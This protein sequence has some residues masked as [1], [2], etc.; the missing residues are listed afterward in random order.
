MPVNTYTFRRIEKKYL[1]NRETFNA[2]FFGIR[3][4]IVGDEYGKSTIC[5]AYL[6]TPDYRL[7]RTSLDAEDYKEK[8]RLRSYGKAA[9]NGTVFLEIKKKCG[10]V[11]YKRRISTQYASAI[12]YIINGVA[13]PDSQIQ[14]EIDY[15]MSFYGRPRPMSVI[16]YEREAFFVSELPAL[17]I[18]FDTNVRCRLD[19]TALTDPPD[20]TLLLP[21]DTVIME[22]KTDGAMPLWL[23]N[24]LD[25]CGIIPHSF[26]KYGTAYRQLIANKR[27]PF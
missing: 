12:D 14:R 4:R 10:G 6:D 27:T 13:L 23:T 18:T 16:C 8:L 19:S 3:N 1:L 5:S 17:R 25:C 7:I 9:E 24:R 22:I 20:G 11:V 2:F 15:A 21:D 26:S